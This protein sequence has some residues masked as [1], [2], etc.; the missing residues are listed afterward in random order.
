MDAT[1]RRF[2]SSILVVASINK[3]NNLSG[4]LAMQQ[5]PQKSGLGTPWGPVHA[6]FRL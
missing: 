2:T 1:N 6:G 5:S 4:L 3:I